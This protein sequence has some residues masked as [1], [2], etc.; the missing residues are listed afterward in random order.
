MP[1][2]ITTRP[3]IRWNTRVR[4]LWMSW[5]KNQTSSQKDRWTVFGTVTPILVFL[6]AVSLAI[7]YLRFEEYER[8]QESLLHDSNYA[9]Q[10]L[11]LRILDKQDQLQKLSLNLSSSASKLQQ[12][13]SIV[14]PLLERNPGI[15]RLIW[16]D[17]DGKV[18]RQREAFFSSWFTPIDLNEILGNGQF[19]SDW[20]RSIEQQR[21]TISYLKV[22]GQQAGKGT[23]QHFF[24][25]IAPGLRDSPVSGA[26]IATMRL[27]ALLQ[28]DVPQELFTK[29]SLALVNA[30]QSVLAG[31]MPERKRADQ[32]LIPWPSVSSENII[33][34]E[35][36]DSEVYL[37]ARAFRTNKGVLG[38]AMLWVIGGISALT[39][40]MLMT[41]AR[42][43]RRRLLAQQALQT[44]TNFRRA[45]E[46]AMLIG[47]RALDMQGRITYVNSAFCK[48]TG[49]E[50]HELVGQIAP[51][52][53]WPKDDIPKLMALLNDEISGRVSPTGVEV[54]IQ[55]RNG[56]TLYARVHVSPLMSADGKQ[57]GWMTSVADISEPKRVREEL[58]VAHERFTTVLQ[59]LDAAVSVAS[60][61]GN[62]LLFA[63]RQYLQWFGQGTQ[64]H[65]EM[66]MQA[67]MEV[68]SLTQQS[69]NVDD[70]SGVP[71][72]EALTEN[73][74]HSEVYIERLDMWLEIRSRYLT[75]VDGRL[76]QMMI[77]TDITARRLAQQQAA[78]QA[79]RAQNAS[80]LI[81]MGE[82]ASSVAHELNQP[83]TAIS[84]YCSGLISRI[85]S[86][87]IE[88]PQLL[89]ALEKTSKQAQR[90][91]QIITRIRSFVQRS[92]PTATL[93]EVS[94]IV[95]EALELAEIELRRQQVRLTYYIAARLPRL[96]VDPILIEQVLINLVKNAAEAI[97]LAKRPATQREVELSVRPR[98]ID[99]Q[100]TVEFSVRDTGPG[101]PPEVLD[102][103]YEAFYTT[104]AGGMGIGLKL[105]RSIVESH[106]GRMSAHNLYNGGEIVGCCFSFW[107]PVGEPSSPTK[108]PTL[109]G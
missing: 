20:Q 80:R 31:D 61:G 38:D 4:A 27:D 102:R 25:L 46:N 106:K 81:T 107:I 89:E 50:E 92:A 47:T 55:H 74:D 60:L 98:H 109:R 79:E 32:D 12:F 33:R 95:N 52:P 10:Y 85:N 70:L 100:D 30:D 43:T 14:V 76:V 24:V 103:I 91:G 77:A 63:N 17:H 54:R 23:D 41:S 39:V 104:K 65:H 35:P 49:F 7:G 42:L 53:Y 5:W 36:M 15:S 34:L 96:F 16:M 48:M 71:S 67:Q 99:G 62:E 26:L 22:H 28:Y 11:R 6:F 45:M 69:D 82:M 84:N 8:D 19:I 56:Q 87:Q 105:C 59:S 90:A 57:T 88:T 40:W 83:L 97:S 68:L 58:M 29:Y 75:W 37:L 44:E 94:V 93:S 72:A 3:R 18:L 9:Q 101:M 86:K 13:D 21:P 66:V 51:F 73:P 78:E 2:Y 108:Q 64:G 1:K